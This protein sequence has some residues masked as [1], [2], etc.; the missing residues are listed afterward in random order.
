MAAA[1]IAMPQSA[2]VAAV[3]A[4]M[5]ALPVA[6]HS[7]ALLAAVMTAANV[8]AG[9]EAHADGLTDEKC[10]CKATEH[11]HLARVLTA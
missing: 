4:S 7:G 6:V 3:M 1:L 9:G 10:S 8:D 2:S 5:A 11:H